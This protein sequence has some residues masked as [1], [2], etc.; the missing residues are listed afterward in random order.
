[1]NVCNT[2]PLRYPG[3]KTRARKI[4]DDILQKYFTMENIDRIVSP[5]FG[6]GSFEF[7]LQNKYGIPI[8][9]N[10]KFTPLYHFWNK[11]KENKFAV[12]EKIREN[13]SVSKESFLEYRKRIRDALTEN[14]SDI[15]AYYFIINRCSFSGSTLSGGF[16]KEASEKRFTASSIEKVEVLDL[17]YIDFYNEDFVSFLDRI[18]ITNSS[19]LFLDP[20]YCLANQANKLYGDNGDMHEHFDHITLFQILKT[21]EN[22]ILTYNHCDF[23]LDLYKDYIIIDVQWSYGMNATKKSSEIVILSIL[24]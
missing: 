10:D 18:P 20:P 16:S 11:I 24:R 3:G 4:M 21:R 9:A 5:F 2:S 15:A 7:Y 17:S 19:L 13:M 12:I 8:V 23:I 22:W 1:M 6:G 14:A